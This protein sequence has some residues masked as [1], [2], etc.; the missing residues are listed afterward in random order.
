MAFL[1]KTDMH[2]GAPALLFAR[3]KKMRRNMTVE[4]AI[5]WEV[6][7]NRKLY[8]YKFRRQHPTY[9][10]I[11]DFYCHPLRLGIE[12]DGK[13]HQIKKHSQYDRHRDNTLSS[14]GLTILRFP[15][16]LITNDLD[17]VKER[18]IQKIQQLQNE[19][20]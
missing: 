4:E 2:Y 15:N 16:H 3:A 7:R 9:L 1:K 13:H 6:L 14:L 18:I 10:F 19:G 17:C 5:L 20:L 8:G 12:V 11:L